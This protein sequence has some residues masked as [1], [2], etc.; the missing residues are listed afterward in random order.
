MLSPADVQRA[1]QTDLAPTLAVLQNAEQM[2]ANQYRIDAELALQAERRRQAEE[3]QVANAL[4]KYYDNAML[5]TGTAYDAVSPKLAA[6]ALEDVM[7]FQRKNPGA[8]YNEKLAY[9]QQRYGQLQL[10][11]E[12]AKMLGQRIVADAKSLEAQDIDPIKF[13]QWASSRVFLNPDGSVNENFDPSLDYKAALDEETRYGLENETKVRERLVK[14][15]EDPKKYTEHRINIK[16]KIG[17]RLVDVP[18][19]AAVPGFA[20]AWDNN[21][22]PELRLRT[23]SIPVQTGTDATGQPVYEERGLVGLSPEA[24]KAVSETPG[25]ASMMYRKRK[26]LEQSGGEQWK[27]L[28]EEAKQSRIAYEVL[29]GLNVGRGKIGTPDVRFYQQEQREER[30]R[31]QHEESQA[32]LAATYAGIA[33]AN[34]RGASRVANAISGTA[35]TNGD[36]WNIMTQPGAA[37]EAV[38]NAQVKSLEDKGRAPKSLKYDKYNLVSVSDV[39][40][41]V[42]SKTDR[43][44]GISDFYHDRAHNILIGTRENPR[45]GNVEVV[46]NAIWVGPAANKKNQELERINGRS[47]AADINAYGMTNKAGV[48]KQ[49]GKEIVVNRATG[50]KP[51]AAGT[52][53]VIPSIPSVQAAQRKANAELMM[54]AGSQTK[55]I[56]TYEPGNP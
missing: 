29:T 33:A 50:Q 27:A 4:G 30:Y 38:F 43:D 37:G 1:Y 15:L 53:S 35:V 8:S 17:D 12:Q 41:I 2:A 16:T 26:A 42:P 39:A 19:E 28:P 31:Q 14:N 18:V 40:G 55:K 52:K 36:L 5:P 45:T 51:S 9:G 20:E 54:G 47:A 25:F 10:K 48:T 11:S 23:M 32:R 46:K 6:R 3:V 49:Q 13:Q 34:E 56:N 22:Q 44:N 24:Y 7:E 21:G